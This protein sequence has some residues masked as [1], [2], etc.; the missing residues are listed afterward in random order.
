MALGLTHDDPLPSVSPETL[1]TYYRYLATNLK[2]PSFTSY[3]AKSGT[4]ASK[5]VIV[6]ITRLDAPIDEEFDEQHGLFC[7]GRDQDEEIEFPLDVIEL[8]KKD[9][10]YRL[11]SDYSSWLHNRR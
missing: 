1:M 2:F 5:K 6:T 3:W 7:I 4:Y 9:A 11:I 10:N 8:K